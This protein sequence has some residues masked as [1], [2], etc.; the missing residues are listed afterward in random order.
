M[1]TDAAGRQ[2]AAQHAHVQR[3]GLQPRDRSAQNRTVRL[4]A[5]AGQAT[6]RAIPLMTRAEAQA[7][8][9]RVVEADQAVRLRRQERGADV[10]ARVEP[11][12]VAVHVV[13]PPVLTESEVRAAR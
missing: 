11:Q 6:R 4:E 7:P 12:L 10:A 13:Y 5:V 2:C 9:G 3:Y 1:Q 8:E